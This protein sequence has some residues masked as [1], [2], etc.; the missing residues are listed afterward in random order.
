MERTEILERLARFL[1]HADEAPF[2]DEDNGVVSVWLGNYADVARRWQ[3]SLPTPLQ[4]GLDALLADASERGSIDA[5]RL[6]QTDRDNHD[7]WSAICEADSWDD[8][9]WYRVYAE[10]SLDQSRC[11]HWVITPALDMGTW[12]DLL[13]FAEIWVAGD[14]TLEQFIPV[15]I[16]GWP[17]GMIR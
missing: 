4:E 14:A 2:I 10:Y 11:G 16:N 13:R 9:H 3:G 1:L 17:W 12:E 8:E 7:L 5:A 15:M 6:W